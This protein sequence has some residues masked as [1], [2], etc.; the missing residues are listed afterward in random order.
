KLLDEDPVGWFASGGREEAILAAMNS[1]LDWL[2]SRLRLDMAQWIWGRLHIL[3]LRHI[4]S[5]RGDLGQLL[6]HGGL[7]VRG[8][9][10]TVCNTGLGAEYDAR[11][12]ANYRLIGDLSTV[13]A[14]LWS[15]DSQSES[16][17]PGS[18]H[19]SD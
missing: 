17:H 19:Y 12:G 7:P 4:L 8:N 2:A 9:M 11:T 6:D 16:G 14:V 13:P 10:H 18:P 3:T 5:G 1:G 15:V